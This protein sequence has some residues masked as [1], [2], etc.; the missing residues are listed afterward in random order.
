[1]LDYR[2]P[3]PMS[4][5]LI[6]DL[7]IDDVESGKAVSLREAA[8]NYN[9]NMDVLFSRITNNSAN[10]LINPKW[11]LLSPDDEQKIIDW[12]IEEEKLSQPVRCYE[13]M[14]Y[15][16]K[17]SSITSD[18]WNPYRWRWFQDFRKRHPEIYMDKG[19]MFSRKESETEKEQKGVDKPH[20]KASQT[21]KPNSTKKQKQ[22][23][24]QKQTKK[25]TKPKTSKRMSEGIST[26]NIINKPRRTRSKK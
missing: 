15:A 7:A 25:I 19:K 14:G 21:P 5:M 2:V 11:Q 8:C 26:S 20:G 10:N 1:M 3:L 24:K 12:I 9:V 4:Y 13:V 22:T 18:V 6:V 23:Q 17:L 16:A